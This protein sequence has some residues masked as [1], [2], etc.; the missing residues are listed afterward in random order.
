MSTPGLFITSLGLDKLA[1]GLAY[2][3]FWISAY[4]TEK[5]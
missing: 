5:P 3:P 2:G 1:K 4:D